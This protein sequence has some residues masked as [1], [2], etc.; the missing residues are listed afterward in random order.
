MPWE[1]DAALARVKELE[2]ALTK[3][4]KPEGVY[5]RDK[6]EYFKNIIEWC[7]E[8][9]EDALATPEPTEKTHNTVWVPCPCDCHKPGGS[10]HYECPQRCTEGKLLST[11]EKVKP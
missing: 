2:T 11:E 6:E 1:R 4:T 8:T 9:A 3:I 5:R 10:L 7:I